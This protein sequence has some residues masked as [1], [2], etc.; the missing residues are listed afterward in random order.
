MIAHAS[1]AS[2]WRR[3]WFCLSVVV[4]M[5]IGLGPRPIAAQTCVGDYNGDNTVGINEL[6]LGGFGT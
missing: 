5:A 3:Q 6:I 2:D 4:V 1:A